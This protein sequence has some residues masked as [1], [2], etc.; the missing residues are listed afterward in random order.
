MTR[1][2][3]LIHGLTDTNVPAV[4]TLRLSEALR[5]ARLP[6]EL[7][8]LPGTG[9]QPIGSTLTGQLLD[10]QVRF[11]RRHCVGVDG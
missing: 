6:H 7:L 11:L 10:R 8:L 5:A 2:L 3:L 1:P 9:H 4:N